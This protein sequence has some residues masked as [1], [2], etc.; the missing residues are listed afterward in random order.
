VR[1]LLIFVFIFT[2]FSFPA[3][4]VAQPSS[5]IQIY[6][7]YAQDCQ[8]CQ[9][10][11]QDYLPTL[12]TMVPALDVK[13]VDV[14]NPDYYEALVK[15]EEKFGRSG[16]ELPVVFIG[17]QMLSGEME[18][19]EKLNP[20]LLEVQ[21]KGGFSRPAIELSDLQTVTGDSGKMPITQHDSRITGSV[22]LAYFY[23]TGCPK[24]DRAN[25]LLKYMA[26][27]YPPLKITE[28]DLNTPDGK[29][30]NETLSNRVNL[31]AEKRLIAPSIFVGNDPLLPDEIT[32]SR[33][34]ALIRKYG[35]TTPLSSSQT[36]SPAGGL[37]PSQEESKKAEESIIQRFKS[38]GVLAILLAGL[39]EGMNPCALATLVF[40]ISY[41]TMVGRKRREI[42]WGGLVFS[43]TGFVTHLLIG[44]GI[45]G[46]IQHLSF[47]P[48]FSQI[49]YF[50]TFLFALLLGILSLYDYIQL[51]KG[52]PSKMRLQVPNFVKKKIHQMIRVRSDVLEANKESASIRFLLSAVVI[53]FI[54]TLFQ[55]T[56]TS[57]V[58]LPTILF[59]TNIPSLRGS[60]VLYL[61]LYNL[62][63]IL[64]LLVIFGIVYWGV[65]SVQLSFFLQKRTSTI[66]L[67]TSVFFFTLAGI[68][69]LSLI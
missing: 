14:G 3:H 31:P 30:L 28:I 11:L 68:L 59:V 41:L 64:P 35:E 32:E 54:V 65:T 25:A 62:I 43:G 50:I 44:I 29:R 15:L 48:L 20:L 56:C 18:I 45:L 47:L 26:K 2:L 51:K 52:Q 63:Y 8:P 1:K 55:S 33:V 36:V 27:K 49:V 22:D 7:F 39:M 10:I 40:F 17:D 42:F 12:K 23:Q 34:E 6:F 24:C 19:M 57:Q 38:F 66:K 4:E 16:S 69:I 9:T 37:S 13:T 60:A 67:L 5:S 58:Y 46:F 61:I 21:A 53:G